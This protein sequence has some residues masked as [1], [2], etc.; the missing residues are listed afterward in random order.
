MDRL[1][2]DDSSQGNLNLESQQVDC[3]DVLGDIAA[4]RTARPFGRHGD[5][6]QRSR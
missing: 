4:A 3:L 6:L 5:R 1:R 2:R